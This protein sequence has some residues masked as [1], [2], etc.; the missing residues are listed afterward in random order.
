MEAIDIL[1]DDIEFNL[2]Q[3]KNSKKQVNKRNYVRSLF[4]FYEVLLSDLREK[5]AIRLVNEFEQHGEWNITELYPLLDD[6]PESP[7]NAD[8]IPVPAP[9]STQ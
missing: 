9:N 3:M 2:K 6:E 1:F 5:T 8:K 7:M 4:A